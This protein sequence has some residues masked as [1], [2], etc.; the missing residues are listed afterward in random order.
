[1]TRKNLAAG[2]AWI[3][4]SILCWAPL[5]SVAKRTLPYLDAFALGTVRYSLGVALFLLLV[6]AV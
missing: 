6:V 1:M 5:F 4:L 3:A 2:L